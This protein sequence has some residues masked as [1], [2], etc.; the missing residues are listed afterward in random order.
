MTGKIMATLSQSGVSGPGLLHPKLSH[1]FRALFIVD[2]KVSED[3]SLSRQLTSVHDLPAPCAVQ[4]KAE[5]EKSITYEIDPGASER[6]FIIKFED[7]VVNSA[8]KQLY[9][10]MGK[11]FVVAIQV[12]DSNSNVVEEY[13]F[14]GSTVAEVNSSD[15]DYAGSRSMRTATVEFPSYLTSRLSPEQQEM[16]QVLTGMTIK[17]PTGE[18][19][20]ACTKT[21]WINYTQCFHTLFSS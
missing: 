10:L 14:N 8:I 19:T 5:T 17:W 15:L 18:N 2:G 4:K 6:S 20:S 12:M 13:S 9:E 1:N 7:D 11:R 21:V 16:Q 3:T